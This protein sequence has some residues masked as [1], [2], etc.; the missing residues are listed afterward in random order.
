M[1]TT[2][3]PT[4]TELNEHVSSSVQE[5]RVREYAFDDDLVIVEG[6]LIYNFHLF[7]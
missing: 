2:I 4:G 3:T 1:C 6:G 7:Y 5:G